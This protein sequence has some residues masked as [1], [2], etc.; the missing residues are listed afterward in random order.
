MRQSY[1][2][3]KDFTKFLRSYQKNPFITKEEKEEEEIQ[4][5]IE[6]SCKFDKFIEENWDKWCLKDICDKNNNKND[7]KLELNKIA[8]RWPAKAV[9]QFSTPK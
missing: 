6:E 1:Y 9:A 2:M 3:M 8:A 7:G 5:R 4:R